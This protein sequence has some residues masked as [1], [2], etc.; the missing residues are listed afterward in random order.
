[1]T[2]TESG[3]AN[4]DS[5]SSLAE[6]EK[7]LSQHQ[8]IREEIDSYTNDYSS[9]MDYGEKVTADPSTFDDPQYMFLRERLN[10]LNDGWKEVHKMWDNRQ[11]LLS[12]SLN[13]QM[14]NRDAKQA[15]VLL[16]QQVQNIS[17]FMIIGLCVVLSCALTLF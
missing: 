11:Q 13:L 5:P 7:L 10:A 17:S 6:A 16:S 4:E 15:E 3:I 1:M 2:K 8:Q 14:F 12:Q 9:M